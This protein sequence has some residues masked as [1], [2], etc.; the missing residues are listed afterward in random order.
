[1]DRTDL[2]LGE[3]PQPVG[4]PVRGTLSTIGMRE[5]RLHILFD[6][7]EHR[8]ELVAALAKGAPEFWFIGDVWTTKRIAALIKELF[9]V[10]YR[11]AR[12]LSHDFLNTDDSFPMAEFSGDM[13]G[14]G[15]SRLARPVQ[16]QPQRSDHQ[17]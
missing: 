12:T 13:P 5:R 3:D 9:G 14:E 2:Q 4:D 16:Y 6:I 7:L 17:Y 15:A 11:P 10:S 8:T 1:M